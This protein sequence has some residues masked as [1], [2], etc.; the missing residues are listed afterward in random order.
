MNTKIRRFLLPGLLS[1][2]ALGACGGAETA[3]SEPANGAE[4]GGKAD[5]ADGV[6]ESADCLEAYDTCLSSVADPDE[7]GA[8]FARCLAVN[9]GAALTDCGSLDAEAA[10]VCEAC[11]DVPECEVVED[12]ADANACLGATAVCQ[13]ESVGLL[14]A[15]CSLPEAVDPCA[16]R[17][18][19]DL[20]AE[21]LVNDSIDACQRA[22]A[23]CLAT[24]ATF[25]YGTCDLLPDSDL[26][27][28]QCLACAAS[29][30]CVE[31]EQGGDLEAC[32]VAEAECLYD[33]FGVLPGLCEPPAVELF[34]P[35]AS[36]TCRTELA[37]CLETVDRDGCTREYAVCLALEETFE[38]STCEVLPDQ[39]Q[40][41]CEL[42]E[43]VDACA[44]VEDGADANA[45]AAAV[46]QCHWDA[47]AVLPS[48]CTLPPE[49]D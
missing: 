35:C 47:L 31:A 15:G 26:A 5:D 19:N 9:E 12:G 4:G 43:Q 22:H 16:A 48:A 46:A 34:D 18:C 27:D 37:E 38:L 3:E 6:C 11:D 39:A 45:C 40:E 17:G 20:Y 1:L 24:E 25:E 32:A 42:C 13:F 36:V 14:P 10:G 21:C 30:A 7:C 29:E 2:F 41:T 33:A 23:G 44:S 8:G 49:L 28:D